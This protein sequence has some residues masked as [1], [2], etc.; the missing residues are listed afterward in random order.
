VDFTVAVKARLYVPKSCPVTIELPVITEVPPSA[1]SF[2]TVMVPGTL[3]TVK[4]ELLSSKSSNPVLKSST[5]GVGAGADDEEGL[6][7]E[8]L[9]LKNTAKTS[10]ADNKNRFLFIYSSLF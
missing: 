1:E 10:I 8:Q 3:F 5:T 9:T 6:S 2:P 4:A 7:V